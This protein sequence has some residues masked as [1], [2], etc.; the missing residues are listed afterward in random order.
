MEI[1]ELRVS[2]AEALKTCF[3]S[4]YGDSYANETFYNLDTL[5]QSIDSQRLISVVAVE[6]AQVLGHTG[7]NVTDPNALT[8]EAGNTVVSPKARGQ[9]ILGKLGAALAE[10]TVDAGF[11]GYVHYPTTAHEIMQKQST[12]GAGRETGIMLAYVPAETE[13]ADFEQRAGR[14]AATIVYQPF[15]D[16]PPLDI[17]VPALYGPRIRQF[18]SEL[19]LRRNMILVGAQDAE[20]RLLSNEGKLPG[21]NQLFRQETTSASFCT[22]YWA[23]PVGIVAGN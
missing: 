5:I 1:R 10:L 12:S 18:A 21:Y 9:G 11:C 4:C 15:T 3:I 20:F 23:R 2:D 6:G 8:A 13:Y 19:D 14:L 17:Y 22:A 16:G 7:L